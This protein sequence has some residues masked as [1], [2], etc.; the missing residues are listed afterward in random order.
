MVVSFGTVDALYPGMMPTY[1]ATI[2]RERGL[3][4]HCSREEAAR[5][6]ESLR[7]AYQ[8]LSRAEKDLVK[9]VLWQ[10]ERVQAAQEMDWENECCE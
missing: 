7:A 2:E 3:G 8:S 5:L 1:T 10:H 6:L 4:P 9:G